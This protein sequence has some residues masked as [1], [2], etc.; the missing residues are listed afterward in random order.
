MTIRL[1]IKRVGLIGRTDIHAAITPPKHPAPGPGVNL[2]YPRLLGQ[3]ICTGSDHITYN[4]LYDWSATHGVFDPFYLFGSI[5]KRLNDTTASITQT[6]L[7]LDINTIYCLKLT[8]AGTISFTPETGGCTWS[9]GSITNTESLSD[10]E[11]EVV[12]TTVAPSSISITLNNNSQEITSIS[13]KKKNDPLAEEIL[14]N[15]EFDQYE[16][17]YYSIEGWY[18]A[19]DSGTIPVDALGWLQGFNDDIIWTVFE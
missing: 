12:F 5:L 19:T 6:G 7:S 10:Q 18:Q 17:H 8:G 13:L 3:D 15:T 4:K 1:I 16:E 11:V 2:G 9:S 14:S